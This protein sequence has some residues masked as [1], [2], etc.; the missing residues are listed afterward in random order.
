MIEVLALLDALT[1][2]ELNRLRLD[3][4]PRRL[5]QRVAAARAAEFDEY[6]RDYEAQKKA[7]AKGPA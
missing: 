2:A 1:D 5:R 6:T 7:A 3:V 4:I